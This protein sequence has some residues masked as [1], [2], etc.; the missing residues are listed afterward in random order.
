MGDQERCQQYDP[1]TQTCGALRGSQRCVIAE[2]IASFAGPAAKVRSIQEL[3]VD[4]GTVKSA[5]ADASNDRKCLSVPYVRN[6]VKSVT[7]SLE[8]IIAIKERE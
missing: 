1:I 3:R 4:I 6:M 2:R 5:G 8:N 7:A